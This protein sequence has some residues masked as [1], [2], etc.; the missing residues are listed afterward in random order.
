MSSNGEHLVTI[1]YGYLPTLVAPEVRA[2]D[3]I[4]LLKGG[5]PEGNR[6]RDQRQAV[7]GPG[8]D[9]PQSPLMGGSHLAIG[10]EGRRK[11]LQILPLVGGA[12]LWSQLD[13][14]YHVAESRRLGQVITSARGR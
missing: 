8:F 7:A 1:L 3:S 14:E 9:F 13:S 5:R 10:P 6:N 12:V 11:L 2:E 4:D